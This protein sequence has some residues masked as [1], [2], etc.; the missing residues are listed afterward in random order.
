MKFSK[1]YQVFFC[2]SEP[3]EFYEVRQSHHHHHQ[4]INQVRAWMM[5]S[6]IGMTK[7]QIR[8]SSESHKV[9]GSV[10]ISKVSDIIIIITRPWP[11]FG[12]RA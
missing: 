1:V 7:A 5:M 6:M 2:R 9:L 11:A 12:R 3:Q 4:A 10:V 8:R